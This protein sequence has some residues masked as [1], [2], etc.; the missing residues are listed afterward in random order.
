MVLTLICT[1]LRDFQRRRKTGIFL[2]DISG[3][4]DRVD[5][6]K[7]IKKVRR[8]GVCE[9]LVQ[10]FAD[11]LQPR[12]ANVGVDGVL[13]YEFV[14]RNMVFQG[15]VLGPSFWN[16][17]FSDVHGPAESTGCRERRFAGD[18][19]M[20]KSFARTT[21]NEEILEDM[22]RCQDATHAWGVANRVTF[23]PAKEEFAIL[24]ASDG[25]GEPF[26]ML[27]P[28]I[29]QKLLMHE[30]IDKL[31]RKLKPKARALLRCRRFSLWQ[32]CCCYSSHMS[33]I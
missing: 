19:S 10:L 15:T 9:P 28:T 22:R 5:A 11:Y 1:W 16:I 26:R 3:A 13:S 14:L 8:T 29:D 20:S 24:G 17:F 18:L 27:G 23:D 2:S 31:Y 6:G 4:F 32:T 33:A 21:P 30:C 7:M 12:Q 25:Y